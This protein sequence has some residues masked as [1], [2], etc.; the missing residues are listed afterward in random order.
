MCQRVVLTGQLLVWKSVAGSV[1]QV[2]FPGLL[3]FFI[4]INDLPPGLTTNFKLFADDTSLFSVVN[5]T[6]VSSSRLDND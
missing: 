4:Y 2:S 6:S 3:F 5:N 1:P